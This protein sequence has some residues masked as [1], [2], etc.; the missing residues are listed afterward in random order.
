MKYDLRIDG[1][2]ITYMAGFSAESRSPE[3]SH[4]LQN[5]KQMVKRLQDKFP[6]ETTIWLTD[7]NPAVNFRTTVD[8]K[9][10]GN[11]KGR[12][13]I[14]YLKIREYLIERLNAKIV[15]WGEADDAL[16]ADMRTNT[17]V[18]SI[19]KDLLMV[20]GRHYRMNR[21]K[22]VWVSDPGE[23][24]LER[25]TSVASK[26]SKYHLEGTGFKWFCAQMLMG[27]RVDNIPAPQK[28]FGPMQIYDYLNSWDEVG[29]LWNR[30]EDFYDVR[31]FSK[32]ALHTQAQLLWISRKPKQDFLH[33]PN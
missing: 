9:Y 28:G 25:K 20:P 7:T 22:T 14:H 31:S 26:K 24:T 4:A 13:P 33:W 17:I 16:C 2:V 11:R 6:G 3:L 27:D 29:S 12:K 19:D 21:D 1:D 30:I 5:V 23:L 10:K 32:A 15:D 8:P 18:A